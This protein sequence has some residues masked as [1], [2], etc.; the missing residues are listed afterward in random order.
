MSKKCV[1]GHPMTHSDFHHAW[2]CFR[3]GRKKPLHDGETNADKVRQMSDEDL[4]R[5]NVYEVYLSDD[6]EAM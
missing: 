3:C 1:C 5:R 4:A 6:E 2:V